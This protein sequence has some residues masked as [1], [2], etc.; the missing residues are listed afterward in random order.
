MKICVIGTGYVGLVAGVG[1]ADMGSDVICCDVDQAKIEQ[2]KAGKVP[3]YE[4]GLEK[5]VAHNTAEGRLSF[6]TDVGEAVAGAQVVLLAVGTPPG[7]DGA[8]DLS[9]IFQAAES[10]ARAMTGW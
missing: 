2:L 8:A 9:Y 10:V 1:F 4:P 6:T 5:L 3:I 7:P